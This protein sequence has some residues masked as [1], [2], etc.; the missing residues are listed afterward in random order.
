MSIVILVG[1][2]VV[3][4][5]PLSFSI[6]A[7]LSVVKIFSV[8]SPIFA[9]CFTLKIALNKVSGCSIGDTEARTN[10]TRP[11]FLSFIIP[12]PSEITF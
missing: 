3:L 6:G 1:V 5:S 8:V 11:S 10:F 9:V 7:L 4:T 2:I 12:V